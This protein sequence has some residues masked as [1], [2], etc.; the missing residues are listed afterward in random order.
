MDYLRYFEQQQTKDVK[1]PRLQ[2]GDIVQVSMKVQ[3]GE[4]MRL[5]AFEGTVIS[6]RGGGPSATFTV[7][8]EIV[9]FGVERIFPLYSPLITNIE[10]I[11][12][13]KVRR[14]KLTYLRQTGRRRFKEDVAAMQRFVREEQEKKRLAAEAHKRAEEEK[15]KAE[16]DADKKAQEEASAHPG[17]STET[18]A[19]KE[20]VP[21]K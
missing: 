5:Q 2:P 6:I 8:R 15:I 7:R 17:G 13:Q 19:N 20:S 16:K 9:G 3:E 11:R 18:T 4:K 14:A 10:I 12:R 21:E 1:R